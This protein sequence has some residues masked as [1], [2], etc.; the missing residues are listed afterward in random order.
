MAVSSKNI[1]CNV[2][3]D[4]SEPNFGIA[5][6]NLNLWRTKEAVPTAENIKSHIGKS[7]AVSISLKTHTQI[8]V[9]LKINTQLLNIDS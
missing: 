4:G 9:S 8:G 6:T 7:I 5:N 1:G 2:I 3:L